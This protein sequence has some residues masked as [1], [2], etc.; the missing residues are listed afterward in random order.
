[1]VVDIYVCHVTDSTAK[2]CMGNACAI[3]NRVDYISDSFSIDFGTSNNLAVQVWNSTTASNV[4]IKI[5]KDY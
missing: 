3:E 5:L 4:Q 1:M 2:V